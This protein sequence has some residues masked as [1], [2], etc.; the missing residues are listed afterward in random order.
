MVW[1]IIFIALSFI[2]GSIM[3]LKYTANMKMKIPEEIKN[4]YSKA[5]NLDAGKDA[6]AIPT[7]DEVSEGYDNEYHNEYQHNEMPKTKEDDKSH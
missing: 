6:K 1:F 3:A 7:K 5:F 2:I 4:Q